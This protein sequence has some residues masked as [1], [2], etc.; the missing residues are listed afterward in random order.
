MG[1]SEMKLIHKKD[2]PFRIRIY[3]SDKYLIKMYNDGVDTSATADPKNVMMPSLGMNR[4]NAFI[5]FPI[6]GYDIDD[7]DDLIGSLNDIKDLTQELKKLKKE[8]EER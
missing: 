6:N 8:I 4:E 2:G 5:R 3:D 1:I 7:A